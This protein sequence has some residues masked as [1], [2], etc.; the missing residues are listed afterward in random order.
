MKIKIKTKKKWQEISVK[1]YDDM[2][3]TEY[4][5][6]LEILSKQGSIN[7][8]QYIS[9]ISNIEYSAAMNSQIRGEHRLNHLGIVYFVRGMAEKQKKL[10]Y[11]EDLPVKKIFKYNNKY[12]D[13]KKFNPRIRGYRILLNQYMNTKPSIIDLYTFCLA[14]VIDTDFDYET[15]IEI[16]KDLEN[17][18][19]IKVLTLGGFFFSS[20]LNGS[21][22]VA[23]SLRKL[24]KRLLIRIFK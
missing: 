14:M 12:Y 19:Y 15:I 22:F 18:N 7:I 11:I 10:S 24:T 13:F 20:I 23:K 8:V 16:Q 17:Y 6:A 21:G 1:S 3:L 4:R 2:N 9:I 5:K